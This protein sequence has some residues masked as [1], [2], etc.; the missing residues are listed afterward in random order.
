V[1]IFSIKF[2]EKNLSTKVIFTLN[3]ETLAKLEKLKNL[4][5]TLST[6]EFLDF[7]LDIAIKKAEQEKF[8]QTSKPQAALSPVKATC[9]MR[10]EVK[11]KFF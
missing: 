9:V 4:K 11:R 6:N 10:A 8:K 7:M 5:G 1:K 3:Q 2:Q